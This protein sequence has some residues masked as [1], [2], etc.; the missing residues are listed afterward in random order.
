MRR[1]IRAGL[2]GTTLAGL[3]PLAGAPAAQAAAPTSSCSLAYSAKI[4]FWAMTCSQPGEPMIGGFA[5]WRNVPIT[6]DKVSTTGQTVQV[7]N[8]MRLTPNTEKSPFANNIELGLYAEKTGK[9]THTYG[10]RWTELTSKGGKT[11]AITAGVNPT[12]ADGRNHTYMTVRQDSGNQWDVLYDFNKVGSTTDQLKV[13]RG[14]P[15]RVDVGLEV[16][17]PKYANVPTIANRLQFVAEDKAMRRVQSANVAKVNSLGACGSAHKPPNC[18]TAKLTGGSEF[19]Q[20]AVSKPRKATATA[21]AT[22]SLSAATD[23]HRPLAASPEIFHG[24]DQQALQQCLAEDPDSC[25][26]TVPG[27]AECVTTTR[28]CNAAALETRPALAAARANDSPAVSEPDL[29]QRA[30]TAFDVAPQQLEVTGPQEAGA[31]MWTVTSQAHTPGLQPGGED[32]A[33]FRAS[34][35]ATTGELLEACWGQTCQQ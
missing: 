13:P 29:R 32:Y 1:S 15:N 27:L 4:V 14:N 21:A 6:F 8:Y 3:V 28:L 33:G 16:M 34:Y 9:D 30:A 23:G 11:K 22:R 2:I 26:T 12:K 10:P 31:G 19:A 25:L 7:G 5:T 20:W 35:S 17:G 24:V 18:F